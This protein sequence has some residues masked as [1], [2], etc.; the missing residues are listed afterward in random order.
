MESLE[1]KFP[2]LVLFRPVFFKSRTAI[3]ALIIAAIFC[4]A[5][6]AQNYNEGPATM[7]RLRILLWSLID[8]D[9]SVPVE[10]KSGDAFY[11][12]SIREIK[13]LAPYV[14]EGIIFGFDFD[15]TPSEKTRNVDEY[16]E[17]NFSRENYQSHKDFAKHISYEDGFFQDNALYCWAEFHLTDDLY[18]RDSR[19]YSISMPKTHG[20]GSGKVR[21]GEKGIENAFEDAIKKAIRSYAQT[22]TKNKPKEITGTI[23][24]TGE[25]RIFIQHGQYFVEGDFFIEN[26]DITD[27]TVF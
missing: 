19:K 10:T 15:Y 3:I 11:S 5:L 17:L 21:D 20:R 24:I 13:K 12:N 9:P 22:I 16:F 7:P 25:P 27:Y 26:M 18:K 2:R 23:L 4:Q 1:A 6:F 14:F 8:S